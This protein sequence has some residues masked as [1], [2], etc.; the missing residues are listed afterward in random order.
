MVTITSAVEKC[1]CHGMHPGEL[2]G[3]G[4]RAMGLLGMPCK[5]AVERSGVVLPR[6]REASGRFSGTS[7]GNFWRCTCCFNS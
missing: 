5:I 4:R 7:I 3:G 2:R 6:G 1:L